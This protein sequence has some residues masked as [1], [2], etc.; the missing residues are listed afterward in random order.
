MTETQVWPMS[1]TPTF[2]IYRRRYCPLWCLYER[3]DL[4]GKLRF[5]PTELGLRL[6]TRA[7]TKFCLPTLTKILCDEVHAVRCILRVLDYLDDLYLP[8]LSFLLKAS[9]FLRNENSNKLHPIFPKS[10][11]RKVETLARNHMHKHVRWTIFYA[12]CVL[13]RMPIM[14]DMFTLPGQCGQKGRRIW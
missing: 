11:L 7:T 3:L 12:R 8:D 2:R 9:N 5:C 4:R 14:R 1:G 10:K 13:I 6:K